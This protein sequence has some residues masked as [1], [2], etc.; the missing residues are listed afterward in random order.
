[1]KKIVLSLFLVAIATSNINAQEKP[2]NKWSLDFN[3][4]LTKPAKPMTPGYYSETFESFYHVDAGVRY[5]FNNKFG[6]KLDFGYDDMK[7]GKNSLDFKTKYYRTN[8]Q[9]VANL[10]RIMNFEDWTR[11]LNLQFHAGVGYSWM[12]NDNFKGTD[13]MG[14]AMAGLTGQLKL[15]KRVALNADF[16]MIKNIR[17][18]WTFDG[19]T[20]GLKEI[21]LLKVLCIT[22]H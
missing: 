13:E 7:N 17:Q 11:V 18:D 9:G 12:T 5:M 8:I 15:G 2:Y 1:M 3:G 6:L 10:G 4:G 20:N 16:T 21:R 14:N 19:R 22:Q